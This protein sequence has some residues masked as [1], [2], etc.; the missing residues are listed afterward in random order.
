MKYISF[1][2][3]L[4]ICISCGVTSAVHDFDEHQ[5]FSVYKT[6]N[7]YPEMVSGLSELNHNRLLEVMDT[8]MITKGFEKSETPDIY[9]NF[10]STIIKEPSQNRIGVGVGSGGGGIAIGIGGDIA[11]GG[12][13][14]FLE[15]TTDLIDVTKNE[16]VW[17]SITERRFNPNGAPNSQTIIFQKIIKKSLAKYP[18]QSKKSNRN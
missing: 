5:D 17:Q 2:L 10:K 7:F 4:I 6:Y 11:I 1:L 15:L 3:F 13:A 18:P 12:P 9:I 14:T 16:L 8:I